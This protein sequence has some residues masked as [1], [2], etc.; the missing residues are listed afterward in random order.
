MVSKR[1]IDPI[2]IRW[3]SLKNGNKSIYLDYVVDGRRKAE[4]VK[5][6]LM[7]G[8]SPEVK[9]LNEHTMRAVANIKAQRLTNI[10]WDKNVNDGVTESKRMLFDVIDEYAELRTRR[11]TKSARASYG[12]LKRHIALLNP[13]LRVWEVNLD[14]VTALAGNMMNNE[15]TISGEPLARATITGTISSLGSV[16]RYAVRKHMIQSNPVDLYDTR[17]IQGPVYKRVY[18][19]AGE[20]KALV[21][22]DCPVEAYKKLFLFACFVGLRY[23][24]LISLHWSDVIEENGMVRIEKMMHKTRH[25]VYVPLCCKA[26]EYLPER[27]EP[28]SLV[29]PNLPRS[30]GAIDTVIKE[31]TQEA[32]IEKK[33][34]FYSSRHTFATL[35]LTQGADLYVVS[36]LLGHKEIRT[37]E[38]YAEIID[39]KRMEAMYMIDN[40]F[41]EYLD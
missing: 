40:L 31:W 10:A 3:K 19:T 22:T 35:N 6:Y 36:Q 30:I 8:R 13:N 25:M 12:N 16:L 28:D 27:R 14:F 39:N 33:V 41:L 23:S 20:L 11:G 38:G 37:T 2:K 29:F 18:L 1:K 5:M 9:R 17:K 24:D 15:R 21:R 26:K 4:Y 7:P 34:T 32:G